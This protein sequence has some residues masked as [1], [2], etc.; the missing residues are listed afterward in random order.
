M[1]KTAAR[2][3]YIDEK[4]AESLKAWRKSPFTWGEERGFPKEEA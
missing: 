1:I 2:T 4:S 3:G